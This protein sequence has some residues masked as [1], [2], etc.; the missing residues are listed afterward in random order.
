MVVICIDANMVQTPALSQTRIF[1]HALLFSK[2]YLNHCKRISK[3][4][5]ASVCILPRCSD[6]DSRLCQSWS[7][8]AWSLS[9]LRGLLS[10]C[11]NLSKTDTTKLIIVY[12]QTISITI[13][14]PSGNQTWQWKLDHLSMKFLLKPP[15]IENVHGFSAMFDF[16]R[17]VT[18]CFQHGQVK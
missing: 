16:Q 14:V 12:H 3:G 5:L 15:F 9:Q 8:S 17:V 4:L 11:P 13:T 10:A 18:Y 2:F 1:L 7:N 6:W